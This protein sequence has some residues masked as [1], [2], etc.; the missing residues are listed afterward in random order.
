MPDPLETAHYLVQNVLHPMFD[1]GRIT[2]PNRAPTACL[3]ADFVAIV[4]RLRAAITAKLEPVAQICKYNIEL[5]AG[6]FCAR[7]CTGYRLAKVLHAP[8]GSFEKFDPAVPPENTRFAWPGDIPAPWTRDDR[9]VTDANKVFL[10]MICGTVLHEVGH[11]FLRGTSPNPQE[12]EL[13]CD[14]FALDYLLGRNNAVADEFRTIATGLWLSSLCAESLGEGPLWNRSH[15]HPIDRFLAFAESF[16]FPYRERQIR[17][18][19]SVL[20]LGALVIWNLARLRR[21]EPFE[22]AMDD[23]RRMET[24]DPVSLLECLRQCWE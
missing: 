10:P 1:G 3:P 18:M 6:F 2:L 9:V 17:T 5:S 24:T 23:F 13:M 8:S 14:G 4:G 12:I 16:L 11:A 7:W 22:Y 19:D 21:P 20:W 15:P